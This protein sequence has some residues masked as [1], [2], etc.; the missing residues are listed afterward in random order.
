MELNFAE[1]NLVGAPAD[2]PGI[3]DERICDGCVII[4]AIAAE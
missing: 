1:Q 3:D 4:G 2:F